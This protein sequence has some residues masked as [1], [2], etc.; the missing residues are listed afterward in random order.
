MFLQK[1]KKKTK[2]FR[3]FTH[4]HV[5]LQIEILQNYQNTKTRQLT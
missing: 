2:I 1:F 4:F 5:F 3:K